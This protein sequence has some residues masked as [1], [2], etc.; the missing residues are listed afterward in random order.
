MAK[1]ER[2]LVNGLIK[3]IRTSKNEAM[4]TGIT[5]HGRCFGDGKYA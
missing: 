1:Q 2:K 4:Y 3:L 5:R